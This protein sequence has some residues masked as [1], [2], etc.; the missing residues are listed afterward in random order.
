[1]N[2]S[3]YNYNSSEDFLSYEFYSEGP[4]GLI[5]K[6]IRFTYRELPEIGFEYFN[7]G[8][9]DWNYE[10]NKIEDFVVSNNEDADK[11]LATVALTVL[12]FTDRYPGV[13]VFAEGS[14]PVRTRK[15]Q[16]GINRHFEEISK[17]FDVFGLVENGGTKS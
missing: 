13:F 9:G 17:L 12:D 16:M 3:G 5:R 7:L 1:M 8:F 2:L 4:N 15:Y 14:T 10:K 11:V 6:V